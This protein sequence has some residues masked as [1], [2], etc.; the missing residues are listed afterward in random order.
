M[1]K[2]EEGAFRLRSPFFA[3]KAEH[4]APADLRISSRGTKGSLLF[5]PAATTEDEG[6]ALD[7]FGNP[8]IFSSDRE[9]L[10]QYVR[11]PFS[12]S[13]FPNDEA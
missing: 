10:D 8:R 6:D 13:V 12:R 7:V 3:V 11:P 9:L 5:P 4:Y 1:V 2:E